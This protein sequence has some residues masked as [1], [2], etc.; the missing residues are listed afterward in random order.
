MSG[1]ENRPWNHTPFVPPATALY[2]GMHVGFEVKIVRIAVADGAVEL[3]WLPFQ[4]AEQYKVVAGR[5]GESVGFAN[6]RPAGTP[7][8][9]VLPADVTTAR[10]E[11]LANGV[12]YEV[13]VFA[14]QTDGK[15]VGR[16]LTRLF[17]PGKFPGSMVNYI[18]PRDFMYAFSGRSACSPFIIK[19]P[20]GALLASHDLYWRE[21]GQNLTILLRSEDGG[22]TWRYQTDLCPCFWGKMFLHNDVLYMLGLDGEYGSYLI[23][24]SYDE[25]RTW[26]KP[27]CILKGGSRETA[28]PHQAPTPVVFHRGRV[29]TAV[30]RGSWDLGFH[31]AGVLSA[32]LNK[33]LMEP[34]SWVITP[35]TAPDP[36][37]PGAVKGG[38]PA[39]LEGNVL[40]LPDG[41][42]GNLLRYHTKGAEPD[43]GVAIL[44]SLNPDHPEE[45][46]VFEQSVA[47][48]GNYTKFHV[49]FDGSHYL[50]LL[51]RP[52]EDCHWR[53]DI[54]SLAVSKDGRSWRIVCD[55]IDES[56]HVEGPAKV[57]L[58]YPSFIIDG[59]DLLCLSR[60]AMNGAWNFH[61]ANAITFHRIQNYRTLL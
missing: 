56:A 54:L 17:R 4:G 7:D 21:D 13:S 33:D 36:A 22:Q 43:Y 9:Q 23:G 29:W 35:Y 25:G 60:T 42:I 8:P 58:Q 52:T 20:S 3:E 51:N 53:R 11:G 26:T 38:A 34:A 27:V 5:R 12:D 6:N 15:S 39:L 10:F 59:D 48:D 41:K 32:D 44:L 24:A 30:E 16:S 31:H 57:G 61:N 19:L 47:L 45:E 37:W 28:G 1:Y 55:L 50:M 18:H 46:M 40:V 14:Q 2:G 49:Q